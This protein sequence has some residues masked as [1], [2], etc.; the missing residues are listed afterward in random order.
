MIARGLTAGLLLM[1]A[2]GLAGAE[3]GEAGAASEADDIRAT[4]SAAKPPWYDHSTDSWRRIEPPEPKEP[5]AD[6]EWTGSDIRAPGTP[7]FAYL[8]CVVAIA[9]LIWLISM[10]VRGRRALYQEQHHSERVSLP[11]VDISA[12]GFAPASG[13]DDPE[14]A[15]ASALRTGD[16]RSAVIWIYA[17][18]L[19]R[20][21]RSGLIHVEPGKT[22]RAYRREAASAPPTALAALDAGIDAFERTYFGHLALGSEDVARL[23]RHRSALDAAL[24]AKAER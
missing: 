15:L 2:V 3:S 23:V 12:L 5:S 4:L 6:R 1:M 7:I 19:M 11:R 20:L 13:H 21:D 24:A 17:L 18:M 8:M 10:M 9:A 22:N 14:A 16:W